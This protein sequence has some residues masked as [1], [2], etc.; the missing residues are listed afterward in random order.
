MSPTHIKV[1]GVVNDSI[2]DGP[3]I[4]FSIFAQG[5]SHNCL[6]C[7]NP[8]THSFE[9]GELM[10]IETIITKISQNPL[11]KGITFSGGDP[12]FQAEAFAELAKKI[13]KLYGEKSALD[14][15]T[16]AKEPQRSFPGKKL[17]I[18][19]YTG[20]TWEHLVT[21]GTKEQQELLKYLDILVDG[22][23]ILEKRN[24]DLRF[25]GSKNQRI[26]DVPKSLEQ[27]HFGQT[28]VLD[29]ILCTQKRW[30]GVDPII[31]E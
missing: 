10:S 7:H 24:I 20:F 16:N 19:A 23:F 29:P 21:F 30:T 27:T 28:P 12:F 8:Q 25:R 18:A 14:K 11:L 31:V 3:G 13:K 1:A 6:G 5:C 26:I 15:T 17:E 4:R 22:P 2:V 9:G